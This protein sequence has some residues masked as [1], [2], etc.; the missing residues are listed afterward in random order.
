MTSPACF[1][2]RSPSV[3]PEI[4]TWP[5]SAARKLIEN[6]NCSA[7]ELWV[8]V[9]MQRDAARLWRVEVPRLS[10]SH[11]HQNN[12]MYCSSVFLQP[13]CLLSTSS[14]VAVNTWFNYILN[15]TRGNNPSYIA[16]KIQYNAFISLFV[17]ISIFIL[18]Y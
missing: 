9:L 6:W 13:S 1:I 4:R 7:V 3:E 8:A 17:H 14:T 2:E 12:K 15:K 18:I 5:V 11:T 16:F 10:S